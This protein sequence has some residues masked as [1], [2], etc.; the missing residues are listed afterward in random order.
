VTCGGSSV[1]KRRQSVTTEV[2]GKWV[3]EREWKGVTRREVYPPVY[4]YG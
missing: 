1:C 2:A 4:K 3:T